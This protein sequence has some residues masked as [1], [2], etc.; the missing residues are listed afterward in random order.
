MKSVAIGQCL[1]ELFLT[2]CRLLACLLVFLYLPLKIHAAEVDPKPGETIGPQNWQ[3]V[4]D[5]VAPNLLRR[6]QQGYTFQIKEATPYE[7]PREYVEATKKYSGKVELTGDGN[8]LH[9]GAGLP[10]PQ[11]DLND[12]KAGQKVAWNFYWRWLGDDF[13]NGGGTGIGKIIRFAIEKDGSERRADITGYFLA[14]RSRVTL[15]PKPVIPGYE[16]I[17]TIQ[18]RIDEYPRD[19]SGTTLLE[20]RYADPARADDLYVYVPSLRRIRRLTTTQRCQTL[21]PSEFNLDDVNSFR[22]KITDFN[23][24][25]LGKKK[26]LTNFSEDPVPYRRKQG[27]YLPLDQKWEVR[28]VYAVEITPKDPNYCYAKKLMQ[29]D[30]ETWDSVRVQMW[31]RKGEYWKEQHSFRTPVKLPDG[32]RIWSVST[33][34]IVNVQNGRSTVLTATRAYNQGLPPSLFTLATLQRV[35]RGEPIR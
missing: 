22:G 7:A 4:K 24:K 17:D 23:Y 32:R 33:V 28:E 19:A 35:S 5:M 10:F 12:P 25:L 18:L 6:I 13:V 9:Y 31:D 15:S 1:T 21:A 8:L 27:D 29:V 30:D 34:F 16:G 26:I 2:I 3:T 20:T 14:P 11:I